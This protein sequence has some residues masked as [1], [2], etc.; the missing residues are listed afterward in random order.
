M[1]AVNINMYEMMEILDELH[2]NAYDKL[3]S[4]LEQK[5]CKEMEE[6]DWL[7]VWESGEW[8]IETTLK[9]NQAEESYSRG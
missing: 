5:L 3:Q 1:K 4:I 9:L 2:P 6:K 8:S 7:K